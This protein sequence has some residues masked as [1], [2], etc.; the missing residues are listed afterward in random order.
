MSDAREVLE[1]DVV[2]VG[3]GPAS[4]AGAYHLG[5]LVEQHNE[6][7]DEPLE[8]MIAILEKGAEI[9][10]HALSG[11]V[12]DP[13]ALQELMP[14]DWQD[15]PFE[16]IVTEEQFF[17]MTE[18]RALSLPVPPPLKNKGKYV[19]SLG[20]LCKWLAPK[21]E[22]LGI[23]VLCEFPAA[24][25]LVEDGDDGPRVYGVRTGDRG[26]DHDG[27]PK[28]NHE[29][30]VDIHAQVVVL[31][32]GPRGTLAKQLEPKLGL[33]DGR[34]PQVY[35][36]GLKE[37]WQLPEG[38]IQ[39]G[40]V[41]HSAG[42]P[43]DSRTFGGGFIYGMEDNLAIVGLVVGLD[44]ENPLLDPH[45]LFQKMKT[46]PH[47]RE[48]LD[49]GT[50][51]YYGAKAIPEGGWWAMPQSHAPGVLLTGDT[52]GVI[53][54]QKL[55]GI[56]LGMKSGMLAAETIFEG[57]K[58]NDLGPAQL[59]TYQHRIEN[60][61]VK[62]ELWPARNFHQAFEKGNLAG[63]LQ[64]GLGMVTGGRGW[65]IHNRLHNEPGHARMHKLTNG[66]S[67]APT[68]V[69]FDGELTFDKLQNVYNSGASH[70]EDQPVHLLV[71]DTELCVTQCAE[72]FDNPCV[73]FCPA[74][75]YEIVD[76][77]SHA[78]GKRLQ[79][80][81][82]NCVHCKTCDIMDPYEVITWVPPEGGGGPN[83]GKM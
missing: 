22:E 26:L 28:S 36:I 50:M 69:A 25:A 4:L 41:A 19:A 72:E 44:Y 61:W 33:T 79:I 27:K 64:A 8:P 55:K 66:R 47:L 29:P 2:F 73:R 45:G 24:H 37:I 49:G 65:G 71:A 43:L 1:L 68:E 34:N 10:A 52:A 6:T 76:E 63:F 67:Y 46:N 5:K 81:A 56:H 12:V 54:G 17:W 40:Y 57:L 58:K 51:Q 82:S 14:D 3:A 35:A 39:P 83:Y 74:A 15:A 11:A 18:N 30:G 31:G 80:N 7:A 9:G 78:T 59:A 21:I 23:D 13:R 70:E 38:R 53:N 77:P 48:L 20:K 60:S 16:S 42:W 62:E 75:V 32:E